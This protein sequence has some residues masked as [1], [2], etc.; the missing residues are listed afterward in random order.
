MVRLIICFVIVFTFVMALPVFAVNLHEETVQYSQD[1]NALE[2]YFVY[3]SSIKGKIPGIV[4]FHQWMG[5][6][7]YEKMRARMFAGLGYAVLCAD[8]YGKGIRPSSPGE[9]AVMSTKFKV[10]TGRVMIRQRAKAALEKLKSFDVVDPEKT[11]AI[12]YCFG[13]ECALE[14]ARSGADMLGVVTFHG[15]LDSKY[16]ADAKN[17]KAK[18][19]VLNGAADPNV[20][21]KVVEAFSKEMDDAKIDWYMTTYGGA[22]HAFTQKEAGNDPSKGAAYNEN[23][24]RRSW[25]ACKDFLEEIFK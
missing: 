5:L 11:A 2:G 4:I 3:D 14:L 16:P 7:E 18:I 21:W 23:A 1:G 9:A 12:G 10:E 24:D 22:V 8:I 6:T 25:I 17:I 19:L 13:G 20:P 15:N